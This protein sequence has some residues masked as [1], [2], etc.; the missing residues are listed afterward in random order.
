MSPESKQGNIIAMAPMHFDAMQ[1]KA[2]AT[3]NHGGD[4]MIA[5]DSK[6]ND[7]QKVCVA[8]QCLH[9]YIFIVC[10]TIHH[11]GRHLSADEVELVQFSCTQTLHWLWHRNSSKSLEAI[12]QRILQ[13][14]RICTPFMQKMFRIEQE[15]EDN[16]ILQNRRMK[17][18]R[19]A[20]LK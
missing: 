4:F 7:R 5:N 8:R 16:A 10:H 11:F 3:I 1:G 17:R 6:M 15:L 20:T 13:M 19:R 14:L 9:R 12:R 2:C 18:A